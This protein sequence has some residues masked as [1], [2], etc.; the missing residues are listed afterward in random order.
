MCSTTIYLFKLDLLELELHINSILVLLLFEDSEQY[1]ELQIQ[2]SDC[3][4]TY[5]NPF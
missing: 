3:K 2:N 5:Q 4:N 1:S